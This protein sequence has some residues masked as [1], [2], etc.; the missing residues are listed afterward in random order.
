MNQQPD[1]E[2]QGEVLNKGASVLAE[3]G[4]PHGSILALQV[5]ALQKGPKSCPLGV[6]WRL[7][8]IVMIDE[9]IGQWPLIQPQALLPS[10]EI[11]GWDWKFQPLNHMIGSP[12]NQPL[13]WGEIQKSPSL[14]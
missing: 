12:G 10:P 9:L 13:P 14:T 2:T 11:R 3:L 1:E 4:T 8:Y 6:L 5:K 7:H